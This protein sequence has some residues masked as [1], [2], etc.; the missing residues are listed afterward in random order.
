MGTGV[1]KGREK[2]PRKFE[3]F[4]SCSALGS[5]D[6]QSKKETI[7][8][9][10]VLYLQRD[11]SAGFEEVGRT[12]SLAD[13][14]S[15][16]WCTSFEIELA[17]KEENGASIRADIYHHTQLEVGMCLKENELFGRASFSV[18]NIN[19]APG[20]HFLMPISHI[21]KEREMVGIL[22]VS[23]EPLSSSPSRKE[24]V[25][26]DV[27]TN[28]LRK[29]SISQSLVPQSFE[30]LR[31]HANDDES[32]SVVWLPVYRSDRLGRLT[33][34]KT[35]LFME[36]SRITVTNR[37]L[38]NAGWFVLLFCLFIAERGKW[39][40]ASCQFCARRTFFNPH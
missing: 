10:C 25:E 37:H 36:F 33:Q 40:R 38:C 27:V 22:H 4:L 14:R 12:E 1:N 6:H 29:R 24:L 18:Q 16:A 2:P 31:A 28:I 34:N 30:I 3:V 23:T 9:F 39:G 20:R 11:L 15:P 26:V 19:E 21:T 5:T 17:R 7:S 8:P 13:N 32:G 35:A